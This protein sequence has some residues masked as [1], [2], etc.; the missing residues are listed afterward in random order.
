MY[1][2][3]T[4]LNAGT[5]RVLDTMG[6]HVGNLK[7]IL[8]LWKFKAIGYGVSGEVIPGG[9]PLTVQ[10]NTVFD[11]LDIVQINRVLGNADTAH[12]AHNDHVLIRARAPAER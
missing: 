2:S 6:H 5:Y 11:S 7:C 9:G 1:L 3:I 4:S 8:G 10:H 12:P